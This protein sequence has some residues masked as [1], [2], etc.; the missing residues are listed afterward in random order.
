MQ[1]KNDDLQNADSNLEELKSQK[2]TLEADLETAQESVK[3]FSDDKSK[4]D[5]CVKGKDTAIQ[6]LNNVINAKGTAQAVKDALNA[7]VETATA[8]KKECE[9]DSKTAQDNINKQKEIK[10]EKTEAL[11]KLCGLDENSQSRK[12]DSTCKGGDIQKAESE[13]SQLKSDIVTAEKSVKDAKTSLGTVSD[14]V[15]QAA[16]KLPKTIKDVQEVVTKK[17]ADGAELDGKI[18]VAKN[19]I[20]T[21]NEE[22]KTLQKSVAAKQNEIQEENKKV[23]DAKKCQNDMDKD[24]LIL[25]VATQLIGLKDAA[26]EMKQSLDSQTNLKNTDLFEPYGVKGFSALLQDAYGDDRFNQAQSFF[27]QFDAD[28]SEKVYSAVKAVCESDCH[29]EISKLFTDVCSSDATKATEIET[30]FS[31][32]QEIGLITEV[33]N[34]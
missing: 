12:A 10:E 23:S 22:L 9:E 31:D 32:I 18:N 2:I 34:V 5:S 20:S 4:A 6:E 15:K 30:G 26:K 21:K 28:G 19:S 27:S 8:E 33:F 17:V 11:I 16:T 14:Q 25:K 24:V 13:I 29:P 7:S 1:K 3:T